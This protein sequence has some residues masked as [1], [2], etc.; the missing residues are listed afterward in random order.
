MPNIVFK[1]NLKRVKNILNKTFITSLCISLSASLFLNPPTNVSA[2]TKQIVVNFPESPSQTQTKTITL[3]SDFRSVQSISVDTGDVTYEL[4]GN[5]MTITVSNGNWTSRES[6]YNPTLESKVVNSFRY[7]NNNSFPATDTYTDDEGFSGTLNTV[8][9]PYVVSGTYTPGD[10]IT[11]TETQL[12]TDPSNLPNSI[13]YNQNGYSGTLYKSGSPTQVV[14]D[15]YYDPPQFKTV[16]Q[17]LTNSTP[18]FPASIP[19]SDVDG[20]SGTLTKSGSYST[21]WVSTPN[22]TTST[23]M[24]TYDPW[25]EPGFSPTPNGYWTRI[26]FAHALAVYVWYIDANRMSLGIYSGNSSYSKWTG[27][28]G[29]YSPQVCH[30]GGP[31]PECYL[32]WDYYFQNWGYTDFLES[33]PGW[34]KNKDYYI[35]VWSWT[36]LDPIYSQNYSGTVMKPEVDTRVYGYEQTYTGTVSSPDKDSRIWRQDYSGTVYKGGT[37]Y[38][39]YKF[40]YTVTVTYNEDIVDPTSCSYK[41]I[42]PTSTTVSNYKPKCVSMNGTTDLYTHRYNFKVTGISNAADRFR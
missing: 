40:A 15:G 24:Y 28:G 14:I 5:Q 8:G 16:T 33:G 38:R 9:S 37:D 23:V 17:T 42:S 36:K 31:G 25:E 1:A 2:A 22:Y 32:T 18:S 19:Y 7:S 34:F 26:D 27:L 20:F 29:I 10:S 41:G 3:P 21:T 35:T 13:D 12:V 30:F 6:F 11:V 4:D 39:N